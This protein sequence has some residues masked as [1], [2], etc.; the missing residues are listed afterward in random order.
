[1]LQPIRAG[2]SHHDYFIGTLP[3]WGK[4]VLVFGCL[5]FLKYEMSYLKTA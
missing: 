5:D 4:L 3:G 2:L 1:L